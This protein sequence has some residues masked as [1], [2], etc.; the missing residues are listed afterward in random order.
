MAEGARADSCRRRG[1]SGGWRKRRASP[2]ECRERERAAKR[3]DRGPDPDP[4]RKRVLIEPHGPAPL[5]IACADRA[6]EIAKRRRAHGSFRRF[7]LAFWIEAPLRRE[8]GD[9]APVARHIE[10]RAHRFVI[11][12]AGVADIAQRDLIA[13]EAGAL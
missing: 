9:A 6:V 3:H 12:R 8:R 7:G 1:W 5:R 13:R 2:P 11:L 10:M 4:D